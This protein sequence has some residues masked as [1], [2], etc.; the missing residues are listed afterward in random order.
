MIRCLLDDP[1][2]RIDLELDGICRIARTAN[3]FSDTGACV[4][5][6]ELVADVVRELPPRGG[7]VFDVRLAPPRNDPE[8]ETVVLNLNARM[9]RPFA[10]VAFLVRSA[11]GKLHVRRLTSKVAAAVEVFEDEAAA[12]AWLRAPG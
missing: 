4:R 7:A 6:H 12:L 2:F 8:F 9:F 1:A 11:A 3:G 10:K 5:A